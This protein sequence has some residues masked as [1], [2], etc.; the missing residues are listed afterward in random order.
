MTAGDSDALKRHRQLAGVTQ[1]WLAKRLK[2]SAMEID[3][4]E[5]GR[6]PLTEPRIEAVAKTLRILPSHLR[7]GCLCG[8]L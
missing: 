8:V 4:L 6:V 7:D 2:T 3:A 1:A 5:S